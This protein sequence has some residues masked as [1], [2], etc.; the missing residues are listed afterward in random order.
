MQRKSQQPVTFERSATGTHR[1]VAWRMA[2]GSE[3]SP[4]PTA[5]TEN[6]ARAAKASQDASNVGGARQEPR[7]GSVRAVPQ[8]ERS[9]E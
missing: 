9:R 3:P 4:V 7:L 1:V 8:A 5:R 6:D 2:E